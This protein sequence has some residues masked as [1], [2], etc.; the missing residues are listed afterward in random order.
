V[1]PRIEVA[2]EKMNSDSK[3]TMSKK[4]NTEPSVVA[5][6]DAQT[7]RNASRFP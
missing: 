5:G 7:P 4:V 2:E 6:V 1:R 3:S